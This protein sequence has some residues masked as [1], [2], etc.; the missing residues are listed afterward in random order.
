LFE[1][2]GNTKYNLDDYQGAATDLDKAVSM[3]AKQYD[4]FVN[5]GNAKFRMEN[6]REAIAN[7][8]SDNGRVMRC[9]LLGQSKIQSA[10]L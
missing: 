8:R 5:L 1:Y 9:Y 4:T 3:G 7:Y 2:R 6:Y 10:G